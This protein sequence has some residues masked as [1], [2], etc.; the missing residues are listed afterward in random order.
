M[1]ILGNYWDHVIF[2]IIVL[3][4]AVVVGRILRFLIGR[5]IKGASRKLKIV[6]LTQ[7]NFLKNA[8]EFIIY[9]VAFIVIFNSIPKLKD[10]GTALF[11][12]A[13]VLAAI[14]GFASQSAFSNIVSGVFIVMFKPFSVGDRVR[15][16]QLYQGDV[17]DITLRH[18]IIKDFENRRIVIP[19]SVMNNET[20]INSTLT[21]EKVCM[22]IE[23][24]I[25]FASN[26]ERAMRI[27]QDEAMRHP[28]CID[29]RTAEE[30]SNDQ[31]Q[32]EIRLVSF[33]DSA[34]QI[35][36]YVWAPNPSSGFN[37]KCDLLKSIKERFDMEGIE[38]AYPHRII[39]IKESPVVE[40]SL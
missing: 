19:N 39:Y 16:G 33:A 6:D 38:I 29:S 11:A 34:Q 24:G 7:F 40:K 1:K 37:M 23:I 15:I 8:V 21:E 12:G 10:Y 5:G 13:G 14:V 32:V 28:E 27:M 26:V 9:I 18:T 25:T 35:R 2:A 30:K 4:I 22:F 3:S 17:E 20:I 36:A 31:P